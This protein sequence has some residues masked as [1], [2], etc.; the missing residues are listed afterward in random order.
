MKAVV[1]SVSC[2]L[3]HKALFSDHQCRTM[4]DPTADPKGKLPAQD[5]KSKLLTPGHAFGTPRK[6]FCDCDQAHRLPHYAL[7]LL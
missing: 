7:H 1:N 6:S 2:L 3:G 4:N 5:E